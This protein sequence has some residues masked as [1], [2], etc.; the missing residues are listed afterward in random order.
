MLET[1]KVFAA[2]TLKYVTSLNKTHFSLSHG[3]IYFLQHKT[4]RLT[5]V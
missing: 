2:V 1:K 3:W 5:D 4:E